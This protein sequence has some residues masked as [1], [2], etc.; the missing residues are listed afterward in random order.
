MISMRLKLKVLGVLGSILAS[1]VLLGGPA[2]AACT[3]GACAPSNATIAQQVVTSASSQA[4][5]LL[6][7]RI[8]QVV[9]GGSLF[10]PT[11]P[12]PG[13]FSG[14][15]R[16]EEGGLGKAAGDGSKPYGVWASVS[17]H[18]IRDTQ[19]G[20][21]FSGTISNLVGGLDYERDN[22][23]LLGAA[24]GY[25]HLD[26]NTGFNSGKLTS[27]G[28]GLSPY[29]GYRLNKVW[30]VDSQLSHV[31]ARYNESR[32][33]VTGNN[34]GDRWAVSGNLNANTEVGNGFL[35]GGSLGLFY[36]REFQSAYT[37]SN[38]NRVEG[39][40]PYTGEARLKGTLGYRVNAGD[41]VMI[42]NVFTR[43]EYDPIHSKAAVIDA[44]G[45]HATTSDFGATFGLGLRG[46]Y[47]DYTTITLEGTTEQF[48]PYQDDYGLNLTVRFVF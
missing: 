28:F 16:N 9:G 8:S 27:N 4:A 24:V 10:T 37:E 5:G 38:G 13:G 41:L 29:I 31:W 11:A 32:P 17:N 45:N 1:F 15:T 21:N 48:R 20:T 44:S 47:G 18:W 39:T 12:S 35:V 26:I 23:L 33:N 40:A 2:Q 6:A 36:V 22:G 34:N 25:E 30:S 3:Y 42:P 14:S 19:S 43:L 46:L 7:D